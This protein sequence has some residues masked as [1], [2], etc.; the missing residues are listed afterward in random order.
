MQQMKAKFYPQT[1]TIIPITE[2]LALIGEKTELEKAIDQKGVDEL[3]D[4]HGEFKI[5]SYVTGEST[6]MSYDPEKQTSKMDNV[7][8]INEEEWNNNE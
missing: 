6:L 4:E 8:E 3:F 5:I 1:E 7:E 2:G